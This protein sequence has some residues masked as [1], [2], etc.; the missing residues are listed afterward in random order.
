[1]LFA[2]CVVVLPCPTSC[3]KRDF[4]L[5]RL[6]V[7]FNFDSLKTYGYNRSSLLL[8]ALVGVLLLMTLI[9][10]KTNKEKFTPLHFASFKG[11]LKSVQYLIELGADFKAINAFGLSMLHVAA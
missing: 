3:C 9:N 10:S 1:V 6:S 4:C 8:F 7:R 11:D 2:V 5:R